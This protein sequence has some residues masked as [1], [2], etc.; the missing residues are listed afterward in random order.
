MVLAKDIPSCSCAVP[1]D[2]FLAVYTIY[3]VDQVE[4]ASLIFQLCLQMKYG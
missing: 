4:K 2:I 3:V 1:R